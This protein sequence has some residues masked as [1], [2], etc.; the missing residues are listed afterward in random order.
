MPATSKYTITLTTPTLGTVGFTVKNYGAKE[1]PDSPFASRFATGSPD[2]S[3]FG[4]RQAW[5]TS[6]WSGGNAQEFMEDERKFYT[7]Y[8]I[9]VN[10]FG[11]I[12]L[13]NDWTSAYLAQLG[14]AVTGLP[15]TYNGYIF[16]PCGRYVK[17]ATATNFSDLATAKDFGVGKSVSDLEV[18]SGELYAAVGS[19]GIWKT[20]TTDVTTWAEVQNGGATEPANYITTWGDNLF[21]TYVNLF[22][23][24]DG[25]DFQDVREWS[26]THNVYYPQKPIPY[27]GAMYFV[28]KYDSADTGKSELFY[29]NGADEL[30]AV[31]QSEQTMS[32]Y[33]IEYNSLIHFIVFRKDGFDVYQS[34]GTTHSSLK[35]VEDRKGTI[36]YGTGLIYGTEHQYA[37]GGETF[38]ENAIFI[39]YNDKLYL[40]VKTTDSPNKTYVYDATIGAFS[41]YSNFPV[42]NSISYVYF[43]WNGLLHYVDTSTDGNIFRLESKYKASGQLVSSKFD[44]GLHEL[45]KMFLRAKLT[46]ESLPASTSILLYYQL[47]GQSSWT[48][49]ASNTTEGTFN[50]EG[51]IDTATSS[52][53]YTGKKIQYKLE[54]STSD[55]DNTPVVNDVIFEYILSYDIKRV[56]DYTVIADKKIRLLDDTFDTRTPEEIRDALF[57]IKDSNEFITLVDEHGDSH[58][59]I[60]FS[61]DT[62]LKNT[63]A[64]NDAIPEHYFYVSLIKL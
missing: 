3:T 61:D 29:Y 5:A 10:K 50:F 19:Y 32:K 2:Y 53:D 45:N 6:D 35:F 56:F 59:N 48:L 55:T 57:A 9:D 58:A 38:S 51:N 15:V 52:G 54:L 60:T 4:R 21:Y 31:F 30:Y 42:G 24:Y 36:K 46:N 63:Q 37:E 16:I 23:Y 41:R 8:N 25:T 18:Y 20:N 47:E 33:L 7:S 26:T 22:A 44:A 34:D 39:K 43:I 12:Q 13:A 28:M 62:P 14:L 64:P 27:R 1:K 40:N 11:K 49:V 17:Y